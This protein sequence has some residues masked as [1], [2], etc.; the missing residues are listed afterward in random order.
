MCPTLRSTVWTYALKA[1]IMCPEDAEPHALTKQGDTSR[2]IP[3]HLLTLLKHTV[4]TPE[5][6]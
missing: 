1:L 3:L 5:G 6:D 2:H 4:T